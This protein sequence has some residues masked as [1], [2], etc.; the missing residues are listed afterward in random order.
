MHN[1]YPHRVDICLPFTYFRIEPILFLTLSFF[2]AFLV[3]IKNKKNTACLTIVH[4]RRN[5]VHILSTGCFALWSA[6][7]YTNLPC[8]FWCFRIRPCF[9]R[10]VIILWK[11]CGYVDI[12]CGFLS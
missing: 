11:F 9:Q 1:F 4:C 7:V 2:Y 6:F 8:A 10:G 12:Y 5:N 3:Y